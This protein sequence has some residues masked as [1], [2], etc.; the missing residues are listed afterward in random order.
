MK[1]P[2]KNNKKIYSN[3]TSTKTDT[4]NQSKY[5]TIQKMNRKDNLYY[6]LKFALIDSFLQNFNDI[7]K[8]KRQSIK[9]RLSKSEEINFMNNDF[10][11]IVEKYK[12]SDKIKNNKVKDLIKL[13]KKEFLKRMVSDGNFFTEDEKKQKNNYE[14]SKCRNLAYELFET[15]NLEGLILLT[16]LIKLDKQKD[17]ENNDKIYIKILNA[18]NFEITINLLK[19]YED[20]KLDLFSNEKYEINNRIINMWI[21]A[22]FP[23][24]YL[25]N[26][27]PGS[28][29][30]EK[31]E[32]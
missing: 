1:F 26:N 11:D 15:N 10:T 7:H 27:K 22:N 3:E 21:I 9:K 19:G 8:S 24:E 28:K 2:K 31:K 30:T 29:K 32:K 20:F 17:K 5:K 4:K 12:L 6:V 23:I 16:K 25:G 18:K 13:P 14:N